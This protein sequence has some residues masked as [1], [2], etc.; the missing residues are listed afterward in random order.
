M[1]VWNCSA[2]IWQKP[3]TVQ[4]AYVFTLSLGLPQKEQTR[5]AFL[6]YFAVFRR[7]GHSLFIEIEPG[8]EPLDKQLCQRRYLLVVNGSGDD[9]GVAG[10]D[11]RQQFRNV[12]VLHATLPCRSLAGA[13][14][15]AVPAVFFPHGKDDDALVFQVF[16]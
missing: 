7:I 15:F 10:L 5:A 13:A 8:V 6:P 16:R 14:G 11:D 12:V 3:L 1:R 2:P 9:N 4:S